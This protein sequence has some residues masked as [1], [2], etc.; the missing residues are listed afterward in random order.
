M[1]KKK[2]KLFDES[3]ISGTNEEELKQNLKAFYK[4]KFEFE[5]LNEEIR[6]KKLNRKLSII[7]IIISILSIIISIC[8]KYL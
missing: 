5:I 7:A 3:K 4:E 1:E 8:L 2:I 6:S